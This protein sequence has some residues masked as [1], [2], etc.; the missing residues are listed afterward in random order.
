MCTVLDQFLGNNIPQLSTIKSD[1]QISWFIMP[2]I[3]WI[4]HMT[5]QLFLQKFT[6]KVHMKT[7]KILHPP[8]NPPMA[9]NKKK[10]KFNIHIEQTI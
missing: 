3:T 2:S 10:P 4:L 6:R 7:K 9:C 1:V 8:T 5:W